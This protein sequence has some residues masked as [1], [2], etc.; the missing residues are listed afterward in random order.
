M[1]ARIV[2]M[3]SLSSCS[4][5][6]YPPPIAQHPMTIVDISMSVEPNFLY[7]IFSSF[8]GAGNHLLK[9]VWLMVIAIRFGKDRVSGAMRESRN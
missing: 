4:P 1:A 2:S 3:E 7:F 5:H 9:A 6:V 8:S